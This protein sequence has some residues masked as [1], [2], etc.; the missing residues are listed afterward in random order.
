[1]PRLLLIFCFALPAVILN[2]QFSGHNLIEFQYGKM[3]DEDESMF[4]ALYNRGLADYHAGSFRAGLTLEQFYTPFSNRNLTSLAQFRL[5]YL[6]GPL[7]VR[8]GNFYETLGRGLLLRS[9][10]IHGALLEEKSYRA[11]HYFHRDISGASVRFR[12]NN[13]S[14]KVL[15]GKPLNNAFPPGMDI[16]GRRPDDIAA[17]Q[18][19]YSFKRQIAGASVLMLQNESGIRWYGMVNLSGNLGNNLSYHTEIA[20]RIDDR[21]PGDFSQH[22]SFAFYGS[23]N[24]SFNSLGLSMEYK[25]Y[26][27]FQLGAGF[28]EPPSLV[29]DH[30]YRLLN[31]STHVS[32]ALNEKGYQAE[33]FWMLPDA[34]VLTLNHTIAVNDFEK[35]FVF[36]EYYVEYSGGPA[37]RHDIKIFADLAQDPIKQES[38]RVTAGAYAG[39]RAGRTLILSTDLEFQRFDRADYPV[40]NILASVG[41]SAGSRLSASLVM[42]LSDDPF[43]SEETAD[44]PLAADTAKR[45]WLGGNVAYR[46]KNNHNLQVFGGQRRGG[47]ACHSGVCYDILGFTGV[48]VRLTSRF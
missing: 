41:A 32:Q 42:E 3:P 46:I 40:R 18:S 29:K 24:F 28:N 27:D 39:W 20:R 43:L 1:M 4:P 44:T 37:G 36:R 12:K 21:P 30:S 25:N 45:I 15:Y 6:S 38:A 23:L 11:R 33:A 34:S 26:N 9:Y 5:H 47:P 22:A 35:L 14:A 19:G 31:R 8:A 13:L 10:E 16:P 7:E 2:A 48:E 17:L